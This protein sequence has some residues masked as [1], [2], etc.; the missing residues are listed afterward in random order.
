M[1]LE[2]I[3]SKKGLFIAPQL[4]YTCDGFSLYKSNKDGEDKEELDLDIEDLD[5]LEL[6]FN[7]EILVF[8]K[9]YRLK[10]IHLPTLKTMVD[11]KFKD[12]ISDISISPSAMNIAIGFTNGKAMIYNTLLKGSL[13]KFSLFTDGSELELVGFLRDEVIYCASREKILFIDLLKKGT[14][15]KIASP[16]GIKKIYPNTNR[17]VYITDTDE[18]YLVDLKN[19][20]I[21]KKSILTDLKSKV[22]DV[23]FYNSNKDIVLALS[24]R[25]ISIDADS[26]ETTLIKD[27]FDNILSI[28]IDEDDTIFISLEHSTEVIKYTPKIDKTNIQ[29]NINQDKEVTVDEGASILGTVTED[30]EDTVRF[31]T[32]DDSKTIRMVIKKSILN[33]FNNVK[34]G[35]AIDGVDTLK[36]LKN[37]LDT[38]ILFLDWNMPRMNGDEVVD[39]IAKIPELKH[40][41]IIM[42]T[43]DGSKEKVKNM[44]SKGVIGY[45]VKPLKAESVN[46]LAQKMI[47]MVREKRS[48]NV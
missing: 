43:T 40:L 31:L 12:D 37:N 42:A 8:L 48:L 24:D 25:I 16:D 22:I 6:I 38:D 27:G 45:L 9:N 20:I 26:K 46:P 5:E 33:N 21:P 47:D 34:V 7:K 18:I 23:K 39:E 4:L 28:S 1:I 44:I 35:E 36:Y 2:N 11:E 13:G 17:L 29:N 3:N 14:V 41:S 30:N 15:S 19:I 32:A 10:V